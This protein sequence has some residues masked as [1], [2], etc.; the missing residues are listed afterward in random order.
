MPHSYRST[1]KC[2]PIT[3]LLD[4]PRH[5]GTEFLA[6]TDVPCA[7][8]SAL[9]QRGGPRAGAAEVGNA[10]G[11][12]LGKDAKLVKQ[13]NLRLNFKWCYM[14]LNDEPTGHSTNIFI[15]V[16]W[17][18]GRTKKYV[19]A[20]FWR[21]NVTRKVQERCRFKLQFQWFFYG[22]HDVCSHRQHQSTTWGIPWWTTNLRNRFV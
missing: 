18:C 22:W 12:N 5:Q 20:V 4:P 13:M 1:L 11:W 21:L 2:H 15:S 19:F 9:A 14:M 7:R 3:S 10:R 6:A 8:R 16:T 17:R